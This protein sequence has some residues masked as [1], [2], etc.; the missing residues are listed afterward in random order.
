MYFETHFRGI[1]VFGDKSVVNYIF[2][3]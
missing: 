3:R 2:E 1:G